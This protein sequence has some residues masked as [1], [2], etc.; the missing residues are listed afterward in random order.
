VNRLRAMLRRILAGG[1]R[2][3]ELHKSARSSSDTDSKIRSGMTPEMHGARLLS[4]GWS[5]AETWG[6]P[7]IR[8][9][10]PQLQAVPNS[11]RN[12]R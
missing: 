10:A 9:L 7:R 5:Q 2:D 3:E 1:A 11:N 6:Q 12:A 8:S 4:V